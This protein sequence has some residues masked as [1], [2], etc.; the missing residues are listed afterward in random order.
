MML[1]SAR[2]SGIVPRMLLNSDVFDESAKP[3]RSF[4]SLMELYESN[5][6]LGRQVLGRFIDSGADAWRSNDAELPLQLTILDRAKY[7]TTV[8]MTYLF[9]DDSAD[10]QSSAGELNQVADPDLEVR[11][12]A[13]AK[14][15]EAYYCGRNEHCVFLREFRINVGSSL[16]RKWQLNQLLHKWLVYLQ[17][18]KV[19]SGAA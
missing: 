5:Y 2:G 9:P 19:F 13:D 17:R 14:Q 3:K 12:Y 7:T 1:S 15:A 11:F 8:H 6:E 16:E 18:N 4:A 10:A